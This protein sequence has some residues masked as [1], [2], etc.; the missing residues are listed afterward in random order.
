MDHTELHGVAVVTGRITIRLLREVVQKMQNRVNL[1]FV[2][3]LFHPADSLFLIML[4]SDTFVSERT[5]IIA[6][7]SPFFT[8]PFSQNPPFIYINQSLAL[9]VSQN[10]S[11]VNT[12]T[13]AG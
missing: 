1:L 8:R 5:T 10:V 6:H 3:L 7:Y 12:G 13:P 11:S 4:N 2:S 9:S